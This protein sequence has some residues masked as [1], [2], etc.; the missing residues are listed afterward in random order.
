MVKKALVTGCTGQDGAHLSKLLL[1]K[2]YEVYG[3]Y[4]RTS[5]PN[6]WRLNSL[7]IFDRVNMIPFDLSDMP[8]IYEAINISKPDEIYNLAAQSFVGASFE[9]PVTTTNVN[10]LAVTMFLEAIRNIDPSIK[11]Y[12]ASTS[13]IFGSNGFW[14]ER[15]AKGPL[16]EDSKLEPASPYGAAK[17]YGYWIN[18]IYRQGYKM[19]ACQGILFNHEGPLRGLEFVTRK[20]T[21][22]V[23]KIYVG[24]EKE[25]VMG[26]MKPAR[27]WGYA[28]E[29]CEAMWKMMQQKEPDDYVIATGESHSV[30]AFVKEAFDYIGFNWQDYVRV[31]KRFVRPI[32]VNF[33]RGDSAKAR[34][35]L[36]W[37]PKTKFNELVKIM[38]K[39]DI[40]RWEKF[41]KG[42]V[43]AWDAPNYSSEAKVITR[44]LKIS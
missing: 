7:K 5:T 40:E 18:K 3:T 27:D 21:N 37:R 41:L 10:G 6:F 34:K 11:F 32:D 38:V 26:N 43:F 2:G 44:G 39:T 28:P 33:L 8:S 29:Y 9:Q 14:T 30:F 35:K 17:L 1:E 16:N 19:F 22:G 25:L 4:R 15:S 20:I 24:L 23:A 42:E 13:E 31:D 12:Q 36:G